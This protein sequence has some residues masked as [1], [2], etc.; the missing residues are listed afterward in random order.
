MKL[1][2]SPT[3]P[4]ARKVMIVVHELGMSES[5]ETQNIATTPLKTDPV[6]AAVNPLGKI[7]TLIR[8]D[9][10]ALYDSRVIS[11]YLDAAAGGTL[12][13]EARLWEALT[14]EAT[15]DAIID[16]AVLMIYE[17]S[18]RPEDK[19]SEDWIEAQWGK[20]MAAL[21]VLETRWMSHLAGPLDIG[22]IS[23]AAALAYI[24]FRQTEREWQ[25]THPQLAAWLAKFEERASMQKTR[26]N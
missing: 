11:R 3:S 7:P 1:L 15:G 2:I 18:M 10:H 6:V 24:T 22:Q 8:D 16:A 21:D 20:V 26:P 4:F 9:G 5:I 13:P 23:V 14:L 12:Y 19:R 25:G 17:V